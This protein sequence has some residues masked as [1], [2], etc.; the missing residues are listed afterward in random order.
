[1]GHKYRATDRMSA[2]IADD[3]KLLQVM[4]RFGLSLGFGDK[5]VSEVCAASGVDCDTFLAVCN[6]ISSGIK[7]TFD[8]YTTLSVASLMSYLRCSHSY[9]LDFL[10]PDIR[11]KLVLAVDCSSRNEVAF[12]ILKF[13][14]EYASEVQHHMDY[15]NDHIFPYVDSLVEGKRPAGCSIAQYENEFS[16]EGHKNMEGKLG[17]LKNI[18]IRYCPVA[19]NNNLLNAALVHL[20]SFEEDILS[21]SQLEDSLFVPVVSML[22][23]TVEVADEATDEAP[24]DASPKEQ[25]SQREREIIIGVVKGMTNKEIAD[26]LYISIHTVLTHRRN[27][28]RKLEIHSPAGLVIYAIVNGIV[29]VEDI[30]SQDYS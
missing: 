11:Q 27:I 16:L 2:V 24:D 7:P 3:Y 1:M 29:R 25:L 6:F 15:E 17:E 28:A 21:H 20:F 30:K 10:L 12:L 9:F 18:I 8:E 5:S 23:S 26:S 13:F 4:S 19:H 22:E 14:D